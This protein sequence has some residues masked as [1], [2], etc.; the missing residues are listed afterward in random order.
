MPRQYLIKQIVEESIKNQKRFSNMIS[1]EKVLIDVILEIGYKDALN[2]YLNTIRSVL[3]ADS[4]NKFNIE[5]I[6]C[7]K[8]IMKNNFLYIDEITY[9]FPRIIEFG[10]NNKH[11]CRTVFY[12][13]FIKC[14]SN[15]NEYYEINLNKKGLVDVRAV[16]SRAISTFKDNYLHINE[17]DFIS[18]SFLDMEKIKKY[19]EELNKTYQNEVDKDKIKI[20]QQVEETNQNVVQLT[21][22]FLNYF[23]NKILLD[24][25]QYVNFEIIISFDD[26]YTKLIIDIDE[27]LIKNNYSTVN[28][29]AFNIYCK[30]SKVIEKYLNTDSEIK[31]SI[32]WALIKKYAVK[33]Y[34]EIFDK[35][36]GNYFKDIEDKPI[37]ELI[38]IYFRIEEIDPKDILTIGT[39]TYFL[40]YHNI[41]SES[42]IYNFLTCNTIVIDYIQEECKQKELE[43]FENK[44]FRTENNS[45]IYSIDEVDLMNGY[46]FEQFLDVL[47]KKMGY[48][49]KITK[50]SGDQGI[51]IIIEK[52]GKKIGVQAKCYSSNVSNKAIQE[53]VAGLK[54]YNCYKGIVVT[55]NYFTE[56][57]RKLAYSNQV[58][59]WDRDMLKQKIESVLSK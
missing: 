28:N 57:A 2:D 45:W 3:E 49:T 54:Y 27:D 12:G 36:Y 40:M 23:P 31:Q 39:F 59:L 52:S 53:V 35:E 1:L 38:R 48:S 32:T 18:M 26:Y 55:N 34:G 20:Y 6:D 19:Y 47:F 33:H 7:L 56:S 8:N 42:N 24:R 25:K 5:N 16:E 4:E 9:I 43:Q 11:R 58:V 44:L 41:F 17:N 30:F 10:K 14:K 37:I 50:G 22:N 15:Q 51:D 13:K 46:E 21:L 29:E